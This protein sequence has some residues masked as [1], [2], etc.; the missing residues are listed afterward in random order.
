MKRR[1]SIIIAFLLTTLDALAGQ[2]QTLVNVV[3]DMSPEGRKVA[4]PTP[5]HPSYYYPVIGGYLQKGQA[6]A[7]DKPP[8][9]FELLHSTA[10]ELAKQNYWVFH[11]GR[12]PPPDIILVFH[13]G[14]LNP[15]TIDFTNTF[16]PTANNFASLSDPGV[17]GG[18]VGI[19]PGAAE[20]L[21]TANSLVTFN[22]NE[23]LNIL[24][25]NTLDNIHESSGPI[26][27]SLIEASQEN[28]YFIVVTAYDFAA[29]VRQK[30]A[31]PLWQ[32]KMSAPSAGVAFDDV[33]TALVEAGGPLFGRETTL[34]QQASLPVTPEGRVILGT[35]EV[36]HY[37]DAPAPPSATK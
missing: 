5:D 35:P 21:A 32:A 19:F 13:W 3:V 36:V 16:G 31:V 28:R 12:T 22:S 24:V 33:T 14:P 27:Q 25:G 6:I 18:Q 9:Q 34:P 20:E 8:K 29:T 30:K 7:G 1:L 26:L 23:M 4:H 11:E 15:E 37:H 17:V 10:V 2:R